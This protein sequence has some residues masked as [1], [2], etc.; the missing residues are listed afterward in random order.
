MIIKLR[1][2]EIE[3]LLLSIKQRKTEYKIDMSF[4]QS[5]FDKFSII[6]NKLT[7]GII[8]LTVLERCDLSGCIKEKYTY[9]LEENPT[10]ENIDEVNKAYQILNKLRR[11]KDEEYPLITKEHFEI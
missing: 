4:S 6:E 3:M 1:C 2:T 10:I 7:S 8:N 11:S 9:Q 5:S